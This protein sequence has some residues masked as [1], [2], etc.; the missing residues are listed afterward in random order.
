MPFDLGR[1]IK[2]STAAPS[3]AED[4]SVDPRLQSQQLAQ[5]SDEVSVYFENRCI[6]L[7][8][9]FPLAN[10]I[11]FYRIIRFS[12]LTKFQIII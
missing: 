10:L 9:H 4:N 11:K 7:S 8:K 3:G 6:L 1:S 2:G 12:K 5:M